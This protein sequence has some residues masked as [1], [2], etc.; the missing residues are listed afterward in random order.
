MDLQTR[1]RRQKSRVASIWIS[2]CKRKGQP[3]NDLVHPRP[4]R[5]KLA[6]QKYYLHFFFN[7]LFARSL[8]FCLS[9]SL[10]FPIS[11]Q[12]PLFSSLLNT[13]SPLF[14]YT[15]KNLYD[16]IIPYPFVPYVILPQHQCIHKTHSQ[17]NYP[18]FPSHIIFIHPFLTFISFKNKILATKK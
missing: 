8:Y 3:L 7:I 17:Y 6:T 1:K 10:H 9:L 15:N 16:D 13:P 5:D 18:S 4:T 11:S 2:F 14:L 12:S